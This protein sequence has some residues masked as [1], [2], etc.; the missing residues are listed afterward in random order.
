MFRML[1][2]V[3]ES[4]WSPGKVRTV[5]VQCSQVL[6]T[7]LNRN[8]LRMT[9]PLL[10]LYCSDVSIEPSPEWF[11]PCSWDAEAGSS[12]TGFA[13]LTCSLQE[14][15]PFTLPDGGSWK[16]ESSVDVGLQIGTSFYYCGILH[17]YLFALW[18]PRCFCMDHYHPWFPT[19]SHAC[20]DS[21]PFFQTVS[22]LVC[23]SK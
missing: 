20:A 12:T 18:R 22:C 23:W 7:V 4:E 17:H 9:L 6:N 14:K 8:G 15:L 13:W 5:D 21:S 2:I 3:L 11:I 10:V 1:N 19:L 16:C